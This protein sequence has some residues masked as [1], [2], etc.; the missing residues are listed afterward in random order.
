[1]DRVGL[2]TNTCQLGLKETG[3]LSSSKALKEIQYALKK[4]LNL[5]QKALNLTTERH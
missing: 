5:M 1:M 3:R 2:A 4:A